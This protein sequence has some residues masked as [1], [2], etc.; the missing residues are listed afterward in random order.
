M[1]QSEKK[2]SLLPD[3][4]FVDYVTNRIN[5]AKLR[6]A[7]HV[8]MIHMVHRS[9]QNYVVLK[10]DDLSQAY[11]AQ[12]AGWPSRA[13]NTKT[14]TLYFEDSRNVPEAECVG[15]VT[16]LEISL[17]SI[18][19]LPG[20]QNEASEGSGSK[21]LTA[22]VERR[23]QQARFRVLVG[24]R[25]DWKCV[26]S[27]FDVKEVLDA[28]HLPGRDWRSNN[29]ATDGIMIRSDLHRLLDLGSAEI[30]KGLFVLSTAF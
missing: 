29:L 23:L 10:I 19:G 3:S 16:G 11:E 28:A 24:N 2:P 25:C 17:E 30:R 21:K 7:T 9:I 8:L 15:A 5:G 4:I 6:G 14:P 12:I 20:A 26:V 18:V 22:E 27:G 1:F 13:R